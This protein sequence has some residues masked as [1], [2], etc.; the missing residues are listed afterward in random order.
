[1]TLTPR[2]PEPAAT[3]AREPSKGDRREAAILQ[4]AWGL[5]FVKPLGSITVGDL[6]KGADISR[7]TFYFYFESKDAVVRAL[8]QRVGDDIRQAT[9]GFGLGADGTVEDLRSAIAGY[10]DRWRRSGPALR[11]M[12]EHT[13][14]DADLREFWH[15][16]TEDILAE[17]AETIEHARRSGAM[18]PG[19]PTPLDLAR[20]LFGM[21]LSAAQSCSER[22][23]SD[24]DVDRLVETLTVV[25]ERALGTIPG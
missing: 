13:A 22:D 11:A 25:F 12:A 16:V 2:L 8:A 17:V 19:P 5:L 3:R 18:L 7:S 1:M 15:G 10:I 4:T 14:E 20:A 24:G 23:A 21:L 6:T 9:K